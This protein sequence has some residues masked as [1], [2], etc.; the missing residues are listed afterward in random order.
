M[1]A[2]LKMSGLLSDEEAGK[3]DL[4]TLERRLAE[5]ARLNSIASRSGSPQ[6]EVSAPA[7]SSLGELR[8]DSTQNQA[9]ISPRESVASPIS[10]TSREKTQ[11][12]ENLS[13]MMCSLVT[14]S[15]GETRYIGNVVTIDTWIMLILG[16]IFFRFYY[17]LLTGH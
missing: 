4:G 12:V 13:E 11:D 16:R 9:H 8:L 3:T 15:N 5:K 6:G 1:E 7:P 10:T 14:N 2:L 17:L